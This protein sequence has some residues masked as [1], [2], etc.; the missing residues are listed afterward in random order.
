MTGTQQ[1]IQVV[2]CDDV[3][4]MRVLIREV[5]E[6]DDEVK[7]IGEADNGREALRAIHQLRPDVVVL[8]LSLPELDGLETLP[9]IEKSVPG[10]GI[11]VFSGFGAGRMGDLAIS[12]GAHRY[13]EKGEPLE[14]LRDAVRDVARLRSDS[15]GEGDAA[16]QSE[17]G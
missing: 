11:V 8:D 15:E 1:P 16:S 17:A 4:E 9:L 2:V 3:E 10:T 12:R 6:D 13:I 5:L 7:V 14:S